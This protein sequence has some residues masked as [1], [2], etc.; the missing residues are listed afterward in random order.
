MS[1]P[2]VLVG[3]I[4]QEAHGYTPLRTSLEA[5][6]VEFGEEV[7]T[8]NANADSVLGGILRVG[9]KEGWDLVPSIAARASPGG[10]VTNEAYAFIKDAL[11]SVARSGPLD[12]VALCLH[13]CIQ[14]ESLDSAEADLLASLRD[15]VGPD[16]PIV[17]GFDLHGHA[18]G[19]FLDHLDFASAYKTNPHGDAGSTGERVGRALA[20]ILTGQARP[21]G[22]KVF[23]PMLTSGNDETSSGPLQQLHRLARERIEADCDLMDASIFNVNPFIDGLNVGQTAVVYAVNEVGRESAAELAREL[24][25]GIWA[26]REQFCHDLPT[27]GDALFGA[28]GRLVVG[29]FGDRVLAGGPGDSV[30][31]VKEVLESHA[32]LHIVAPVTDPTALDACTR[33]GVGGQL[34]LS[35]GG[36][37]TK[38]SASVTLNGTVASVGNR[39]YVNRGAFMRGATLRIGD[40]A[41][42]RCERATLLITREPLMSQDPG[43][44]LDV[45]IDLDEAD[46]VVVKSGYHF[47]LAFTGW[48]QCLSIATPGLTVFDPFV[49]GLEK[50]RPVYPLDELS[51]EARPV[52]TRDLTAAAVQSRAILSR[53]TVL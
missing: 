49:L 34:T 3:Q 51:Y 47:K 22:M 12:A 4:F 25:E 43:C 2:R 42:L 16:V 17:A 27:L 28:A 33:A 5:F 11:L 7:I 31:V 35:V 18:G 23:V 24:G 10:R 14:T 15:I 45:G 36:R 19:G 38:N 40:Y 30:Y 37:I 41:V 44:F 48:G 32:P 8:E 39:T 46:I 21:V 6:A 13:G 52:P 26:A 9:A 20:K 1:A 50:A 29:D 53:R